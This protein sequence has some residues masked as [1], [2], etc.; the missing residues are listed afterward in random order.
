VDITQRQ[1]QM[2]EIWKKFKDMGQT[3]INKQIGELRAD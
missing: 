2:L 1:K 3:A